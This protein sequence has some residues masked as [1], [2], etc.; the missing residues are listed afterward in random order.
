MSITGISAKNSFKFRNAN[1][2]NKQ[3][4]VSITITYEIAA[5]ATKYPITWLV[6]GSAYTAGSPTTEVAEGSTITTL[7]TAPTV[8]SACGSKVFV[9]WSEDN[10]GSTPATAAPADLFTTATA[11][12]TVTGATT[13]Y[14]VFATEAGGG[15][16][17]LIKTEGFETC[18]AGT[19]YNSDTYV[20]GSSDPAW[21]MNYGNFSTVA[22]NSGSKGAQFRIYY[23]SS[24]GFGE[25]KTTT[26]IANV[27]KFTY[28]AKVSATNAKLSIYYST[29][30][31]NWVA[32]EENKTL[33]TSFA[34]YT[35]TVSSTGLD[36]VYI[37]FVAAGSRP[38]RGNTQISIDDISIYGSSPTTYSDYITTCEPCDAPSAELS[39][40]PAE[41]SLNLGE[42]G[43]ASTTLSTAGGNGGTVT[44]SASPS[45]GATFSGN[46]VTFSA[47]GTYTITAS[48]AKNGT[49]C[50]QNA[51]TTITVTENP[52]VNITAVSPLTLQALCGA[53]ATG[54]VT[55]SG[56]NLGT[57]DIALTSDKPLL[58]TFS[59]AT[60]TPTDGK[61]SGQTVTVTYTASTG[62]S[63]ESGTA[64]ITATSGTAT[65]STSVNY[66][67]TGCEEVTVRFIDHD[68]TVIWD[69]KGYAQSTI[70]N[71]PTFTGTCTSYTFDGWSETPVTDASTYTEVTFPYTITGEKTLYAVYRT[72]GGSVSSDFWVAKVPDELNSGDDYILTASY[73]SNEYALTCNA[74]TTSGKLATKKVTTTEVDEIDEIQGVTDNTIVWKLVGDATNG[75]AFLSHSTGTYLTV[76]DGNLVLSKE[77]STKYKFTHPEAGYA[78]VTVQQASGTNYLSG[79][80]SGS[81]VMFNDYSSN[82]LT[83]YLY[84]RKSSNT[85]TT[86]PTCCSSGQEVT[87]VP[88]AQSI[89]LGTDGTATTT[90]ATTPASGV[91]YS[92]YP[93]TGATVATDGTFTATAAGVYTIIATYS[94]GSCSSSGSNFVAV[95]KLPV[96]D[97]PTIDNAAFA[98]ICGDTTSMNAAATITLTNCNLTKTVTV[99]APDGFLVSTNKTDKTKYAESL[100]LTPT[101]SGANQG[102]ITGN[103][104]VRAYAKAASDA[105]YSGEITFTGDEIETR[106]VAVSSTVT[107]DSYNIVFNN[108]GAAYKTES[109]W[110]TTTVDAPA[111]P[112]GVCTTPVAYEFAGW[113][114]ERITGTA[115][116]V[117]LVTFP[118]TIPKG[119]KT[120]YAVYRWADTSSGD[121][122]YHLVT[123]APSDWSGEYLIVSS[124][125]AF[126]G[127]LSTLDAA[128]NNFTVTI[129]DNTITASTD[130]EAKN[131]TIA[132]DGDYYT[133]QSKSGKYIGATAT[134]KLNTATTVTDDKRH[135]L[136]IDSDNNALIVPNKGNTANLKLQTNSGRFRYYTTAQTAVQL[137]CKATSTNYYTT[138][139]V[140]GPY[141]LITGGR[142]VYVTSGNAGTTRSSVQS[143]DTIRFVAGALKPNADDS[144]PK[145]QVFA[146]Q[147]KYQHN[148]SDGTLNR[149][150]STD[151]SQTV[152][153]N[154]DEYTIEGTIVVT[155]KPT[156]NNTLETVRIVPNILYNSGAM[157]DS[158]TVYA[159]ALPDKFVI[160]AQNGDK[161]YALPADMYPA[162][163]YAGNGQLTVDNPDNP[164]VAS[165]APDNTI[166][167][168]DGQKAGSDLRYV[169]FV[170]IDG[171]YLWASSSDTGIKNDAKDPAGSNAPYNWLLTSTDNVSYTFGNENTARTLS[172][173]STKF[174]M[175]ASG[176]G[177]LRILPIAD[178]CAYSP[179]P[180]YL[181]A[182]ER[183]STQAT[184]AWN[185]VEGAE[186]Y[187]YSLD[188][189]EWTPI[190]GIDLADPGFTVTG[191]GVASSHTFAVRAKHGTLPVCA[192]TAMIAFTTANCDNLVTIAA[193]GSV[194]DNCGTISLTG[195]NIAI[196]TTGT[197]PA[198]KWGVEYSLTPDFAKP[199]R[200]NLTVTSGNV[201]D[202]ATV[203][204]PGTY[205]FRIYAENEVGTAY[206]AQFATCNVAGV[207]G[208][209]IM[210]ENNDNT[211]PLV[212]GKASKRLV[213]Y[214][215]SSGAV[216][217][218]V[219][220]PSD[221]PGDPK[222]RVDDADGYFYGTAMGVYTVT[223]SQ[224]PKDGY[225]AATATAYIEV[226]NPRYHSFVTNCAELNNGNIEVIDQDVDHMDVVVDDADMVKLTIVRDN[227]G[228]NTGQTGGQAKGLFF[229]KYFEANGNA[230]ILAIYN[231]TAEKISL[232]NVAIY[233]GGA[234]VQLALSPYGHK[235]TGWIYPGE[236]I[237]LYNMGTPAVNACMEQEATYPDWYNANSHLALQ[238]SGKNTI[239]LVDNDTI[240]D[241][242]GAFSSSAVTN[243]S[244]AQFASGT[245]K[246]SWGD[247]RGF[248]CA[249]GDNIKTK[250][251]TETD[252][253]LSTNRCLLIRLNT[254]KDGLDAVA[255]NV[256]G[257]FNTLCE[258]WGGFHIDKANS[259]DNGQTESCEG[260]AY[261]GAFDYNE[262]FDRYEP[263]SDTLKITAE[264]VRQPDGTFRISAGDIKMEGFKDFRDLACSSIKI[265]GFKQGETQPSTTLDYKV[266]IIVKADAQ[267]DDAALFDIGGQGRTIC[268][269]C[270]V[271]IRDAAKLQV[272]KGGYNQLRDVYVY[273]TGRLQIEDGRAYNARRVYVSSDLNTVGYALVEGTLSAILGV[274]HYKRIDALAWYDFSL[275]YDCKV[276]DIARSNGKTLGEYGT[277]W[278]IK[279]YDGQ[280]RANTGTP[281]G[282]APTNWEHVPATGTLKAGV[283]YIIGLGGLHEVAPNLPQYKVRISLPNVSGQVY[284]E[285]NTSNQ[286]RPVT[287]YTGP[288]AEE[289]PC[290]RGWNYIGNPFI[291]LFDGSEQNPEWSTDLLL[292]GYYTDGLTG[293][294][295]DYEKYPDIYVA[296]DEGTN[297]LTD[298]VQTKASAAKL[299][300]FRA[301]FV[302]AVSDGYTD[303]AKQ[304][305]TLPNMAPARRAT[306]RGS[307]VSAFDLVLTD[308]KQA[309]GSARVKMGD[310]FC[311]VYEV[312][313][314]M[315][316]MINKRQ[317][318]PQP[319]T[320]DSAGYSMIC[321]AID[322]ETPV[323]QTI[324]VGF[325]TRTKGTYTFSIDRMEGMGDYAAVYLEDNVE[326][327][328]TD[329]LQGAYTFSAAA[330]TTDGRF[331]IYLRENKVPTEMAGHE[332]QEPVIY[333]HGDAIVIES[334]PVG[335]QVRI[336]DAVG[337][338]LHR[339]R[340]DGRPITFS[341]PVRGA[342]VIQVTSGNDSY[343]IKTIL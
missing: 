292:N 256:N 201:A 238:F 245:V 166:Y 191:L 102:K 123:S 207:A 299:L 248:T 33:T 307:E 74:A 231:G 250:D 167:T 322:R 308:S 264:G 55:V 253:G 3:L 239:A 44:Y 50:S 297:G 218:T 42:S 311:K 195:L 112:T 145:V 240:I 336:V 140:C 150:I 152:T 68:G 126:D 286:T 38:S 177:D 105:P 18:T 267:T 338:V 291:S 208:L 57:T 319:Y 278:F 293:Q 302:Q 303:F 1:E 144:V 255:R 92:V 120:L 86:A 60:I 263:I 170:G 190:A 87:V 157:L 205:Y 294:T 237:I 5:P 295:Y 258:E 227:T 178:S 131:F 333:R 147:A 101:A 324:P 189:G 124:G 310:G 128:G 192:D 317:A 67:T 155:Y 125:K 269:D 84:V 202:F 46:T 306:E 48:Q 103:V 10:I 331:S 176:T 2:S 224:E 25:L 187:Q 8:P 95:T 75:Y 61:V 63:T 174:G 110:A 93:T 51:T 114:E 143:Q 301:F 66:Q 31:I 284:T 249:G 70:D 127:S 185:A 198:T 330:G 288:K 111:D 52:V 335:A 134:G 139:P 81:V 274:G 223:V 329:L 77:P 119:G 290:H 254:V 259:V 287:G 209:K 164:T 312:G 296:V 64:T 236:E 79:Y 206:S 279:Y 116:S 243:I 337:R 34:Q 217:W 118:Y 72:S 186:A 49:V 9:G 194:T 261:V 276:A 32:I 162:G 197:C 121:G 298:W 19:T 158:A 226:R 213:Y 268:P 108:R 300:P 234:D 230:K 29:D 58:I 142:E 161:W 214:S 138:S 45:A 339:Q 283:G 62:Q 122:N 266:P 285:T 241:I 282:A 323:N 172:L 94:D 97:A 130:T 252:Y 15:E 233:K 78:K 183:K 334:L 90:I 313:H 216:T 246:P 109:G 24:G 106:T 133:I 321:H 104:Y 151:I 132:K 16:E 141:L 100:T 235:E 21:T 35:A 59:P 156:A 289:L 281:N 315:V 270:D 175:Y 17:S 327:T 332:G 26:A 229:S 96:F 244:S 113:S 182:V 36:N 257:L 89:N 76:T 304:A 153:Q 56:Y 160:A 163:T 211:A 14:A 54:S 107:C 272:V 196:D 173:S 221:A 309:Q 22:K 275:P 242:I 341:T 247:D 65:N 305:R 318:Y 314:D 271:V 149:N 47:A 40:T 188:G 99:T 20:T 193:S 280:K 199:V 203:N 69:P 82:S 129:S 200:K 225:C 115:T 80:N 171:K 220:H 27:T 43:T 169:R 28:Y 135:N 148:V 343:S 37:R 342:Y 180:E 7:P 154:G 181:R 228:N 117:S 232:A 326:H 179:K 212:G 4:R 215:E 184:F 12:P 325:Y 165:F 262:Y 23:G 265:Q 53:A 251:V 39:V 222:G 159:R 210:F 277:D 6:N 328:V 73:N 136:S 146:N 273:P 88:A 137:Y 71:P 41:A 83:L 11:A 85:Y 219:S 91:T 316:R 340:A 168:F 13:Y 204:E 98:A 320:I 260:M 30:G